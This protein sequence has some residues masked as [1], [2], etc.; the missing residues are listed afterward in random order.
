MYTSTH[1]HAQIYII[2]MLK[3]MFTYLKGFFLLT[4]E[5]LVSP[6]FDHFWSTEM[7]SHLLNLEASD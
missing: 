2:D 6:I 7:E 1:T 4:T 3:I 5:L